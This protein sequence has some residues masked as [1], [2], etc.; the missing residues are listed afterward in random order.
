MKRR[1]REREREK[2]SKS[3]RTDGGK[4]GGRASE[5]AWD[6]WSS[7]VQSIRWGLIVLR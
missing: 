2:E 6:H 3:E 5:Y 4:M 1:E 7:D